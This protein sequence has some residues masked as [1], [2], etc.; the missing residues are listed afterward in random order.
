M[1]L[2]AY[3][4]AGKFIRYSQSNKPAVSLDGLSGREKLSLLWNGVDR[5]RPVNNRTPNWPYESLTVQSSK[6]IECW[7][8]DKED[9]IGTILLFHG[10]GGCKGG[11]LENASVFRGM[12]YNTLLV[13]FMGSGGSEGMETSIG[14]WEG[15][16]VKDCFQYAKK[17]WG[18]GKIFYCSIGHHLKDFE[19]LNVLKLISQGIIWAAR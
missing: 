11:L 1:N 3:N 17:K 7:A 14:Y 13:D 8:S 4:H 10:Y 5:A 15:E 19:N 16:Q 9:A 12:G 18:D 2:V 6:S